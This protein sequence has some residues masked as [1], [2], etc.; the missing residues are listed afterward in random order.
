MCNYKFANKSDRIRTVDER[1]RTVNKP[2]GIVINIG[3][4][5]PAKWLFLVYMA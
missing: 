4:N 2:D 1:I 3:N 5:Y